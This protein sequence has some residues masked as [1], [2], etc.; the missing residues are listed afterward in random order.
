MRAARDPG[1]NVI[2][3]AR[4]LIGLM[5][6]SLMIWCSFKV[7][8]GRRTFAEHI[9]RIGQ[10]EEARELLDSTRHTLTPVFRDATD[11]MLGEYIEAPTAA[12]PARTL[13]DRERRPG[14]PR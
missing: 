2:R 1:S 4:S 11:R 6:L 7:P 3:L 5:V 13:V 10:T 12:I 8:L 14:R 9:D